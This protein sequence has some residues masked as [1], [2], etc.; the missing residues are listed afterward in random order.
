MGEI[1]RLSQD[2]IHITLYTR[3]R[4][5]SWGAREVARRADNDR[6]LAVVRGVV[7]ELGQW[8]FEVHTKSWGSHLLEALLRGGWAAPAV[9]V[10]HAVF[11]QGGIP[12][13]A[14]LRSYLN[15]Q[16]RILRPRL[17]KTS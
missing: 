2:R 10:G 15:E 3:P 9:M 7:K 1:I 4:V 17:A 5:L 8:Y 14:R 11:S 12:D 13:R 6:A 16:I